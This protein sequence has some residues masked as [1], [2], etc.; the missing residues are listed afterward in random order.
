LNARQVRSK[1]A[2]NGVTVSLRDIFAGAARI[3]GLA[4]LVSIALLKELDSGCGAGFYK[5]FAPTGRKK[6]CFK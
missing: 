6:A 4:P 5:Y 3:I 2:P 1:A